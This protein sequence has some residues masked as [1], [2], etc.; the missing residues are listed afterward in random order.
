MRNAVTAVA[1]FLAIVAVIVGVLYYFDVLAQIVLLVGLG[2]F[3]GL[4][5]LIVVGGVVLIFALPYFLVTKTPKIDE[6][7]NYRLED[8]KGKE[9]DTK[10]DGERKI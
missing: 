6:Y 10:K 5:V 2:V 8:A 9:E 3:V 1:I 7:G 4:I